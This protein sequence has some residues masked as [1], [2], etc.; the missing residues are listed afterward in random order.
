MKLKCLLVEDKPPDL[1]NLQVAILEHCKAL[2]I[3]GKAETLSEAVKL[4]REQ[5]PDI[6]FL[7]VELTDG[8][9]FD[10]LESLGNITSKVVLV[11]EK[12]KYAL[13]AFKVNAVDFLLKPVCKDELIRVESKLLLL[14]NKDNSSPEKLD[15]QSGKTYSNKE[16]IIFHDTSGLRIIETETIEF[17]TADNNY[18]TLYL[19][20]KSKFTVTKSIKELENLLPDATFFRVH[21]SH[22]VNIDKLQKVKFGD[23]YKAIMNSGASINIS[24]RRVQQLL[25]KL[26]R[27]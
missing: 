4:F 13:K 18:C 1:N 14:M 19:E 12:Q 8:T 5:K 2:T 25:Q 11:T 16:K 7:N 21:K 6:I 20:N 10:L 26:K 17:L 9:G 15:G 3:V 22:I 24:R 23:I 27:I